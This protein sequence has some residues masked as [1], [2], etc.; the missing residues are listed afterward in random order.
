MRSW[1]QVVGKLRTILWVRLY[2]YPQAVS[3]F[4]GTVGKPTH[5]YT[6]IQH[7]VPMV[8]HG[9]FRVFQSVTVP[10]L[11]TIHTT[12]KNKHFLNNFIIVNRST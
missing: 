1:G 4:L 7:T 6:V 9:N 10:V 3:S 5:L 2:C 11:P 12:Y 8:I